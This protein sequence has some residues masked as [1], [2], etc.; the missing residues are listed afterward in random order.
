MRDQRLH[1]VCEEAACPNIGECW[2]EGTATFLLLGDTCT[3]DCGF[4]TVKSGH[5]VSP[6]MDEPIR[7]A[8]TVALMELRHAVLTSVT[9]DDLPDGGALFFARTVEEIRVRQPGCTIEVL[10]PDFGGQRSALQVV[11][12]SGPDI[13]N[14]NLETV[15]RLYPTVRPQADLCRSLDMLRWAREMHPESLTKSGIMVGLGETWDEVLLL[16]DR[17]RAV[18]C[19]ILTVGQ[20]LQP[21]AYHLPI[22]RYYTPDEFDQLGSEGLAR[23]FTWMECGPLVRSSYH[24]AA[25]MGARHL[26]AAAGGPGV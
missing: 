14:H 16:M 9:R 5:P 23:G 10:I 17:L 24:A 22:A 21:S 3:R 4:C 13:L 8:K 6:D 7:V 15:E 20:Y 11:M 25:Q 12:D 2:S 26:S 18:G 19:D 1:T